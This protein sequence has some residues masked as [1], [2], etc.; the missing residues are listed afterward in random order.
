[1]DVQ[2][3]TA[4]LMAF[5]KDVRSWANRGPQMSLIVSILLCP[6]W[7]RDLNVRRPKAISRDAQTCRSS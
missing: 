7:S 2:A 3:A 1:V 6:I 4:Q 5:G